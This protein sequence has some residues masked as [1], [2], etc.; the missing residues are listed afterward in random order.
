[1]QIGKSLSATVARD[2]IYAFLGNRLASNE[3]KLI[4]EPDYKK[5]EGEVY[6]DTACALLK[7]RIESPYVL[8]FVQHS[9]ADEV[10]GSNGPSWIPRWNKIEKGPALFY[11]I[12]NVGLS[13]KA[14][15][16]VD[17]LQYRVDGG[18]GAQRLTLQGFEFDHLTWT[19]ELLKTENFSL[20]PSQWDTEL[21]TSQ[22]AYIE[23]LWTSVPSV[24]KRHRGGPTE[25]LEYARYDDE[26]SYA[27]VTGYTNSRMVNSREHRRKFKAY[28]HALQKACNP[29]QRTSAALSPKQKR[30]DTSR[31]EAETH[32]CSNRRLAVTNLGHF[33][34]V[35]QFAQAGD[36]C[37]VFLG[38]A[39]P[40]VLRPAIVR[41]G[42]RGKA[43]HLVGEAYIHGVM[44]GEGVAALDRGEYEKKDITLM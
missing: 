1:L 22:H 35:P 8:S 12:G 39:T 4:L 11:T 44:G 2:H 16:P 42:D 41:N 34:L 19:S 10:T 37:C 9:S 40:F 29:E 6:Y 17:R 15:G 5:D 13:H 43:H 20:N 26:F 38:M 30:C 28:L 23:V 31:Y 7:S 33:A 25:P 32:N 18:L 21:R 3:G 27:L 24:F 14:G 36:V